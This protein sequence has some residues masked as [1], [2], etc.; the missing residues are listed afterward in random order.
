MAEHSVG[1]CWERRVQP[2]TDNRYS[3]AHVW[4][5]DGGAVVQASSSPHVV[6]LPYSN[7]AAV[8][9]EEAFVASLSSC[10]ML[11]FLSVAAQRGFCVDSYTDDAVGIL[12]K[13]VHGKLAMT[14]VTLRPAA[15]FSGKRLPTHAEVHTLH[16]EAHTQ[17][18]LANSVKTDIRCEP[19][20][21]DLS[22]L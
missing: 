7:A 13:D 10:H 19:V 18:F 17:C 15:V 3:R 12:E 9:P 22:D 21:S 20:F 5:F 14:R 11:W 6:P 4:N 8:D 2:F 1:V 16:H